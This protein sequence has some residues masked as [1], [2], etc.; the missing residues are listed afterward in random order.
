MLSFE[1]GGM[2]QKEKAKFNTALYGVKKE[3][4]TYRGL[5]EIVGGEKLGRGSILVQ[6]KGYDRIKEIFDKYKI[7]TK[8][9]K[10]WI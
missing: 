8:E 6:E 10:V 1:L 9:L 3:K 5:L 7:K 2:S 4:Y